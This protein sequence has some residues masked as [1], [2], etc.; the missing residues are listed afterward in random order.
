ML[1]LASAERHFHMFTA[2]HLILLILRRYSPLLVDKKVAM[3]GQGPSPDFCKSRCRLYRGNPSPRRAVIGGYAS[4][5]CSIL[6]LCHEVRC[7][8]SGIDGNDGRPLDS[9]R[10]NCRWCPERGMGTRELRDAHSGF[11][12][13]TTNVGPPC[14]CCHPLMRGRFCLK[15]QGTLSAFRHAVKIGLGWWARRWGRVSYSSAQSTGLER[16]TVDLIDGTKFVQ[17]LLQSLIRGQFR[18]SLLGI[19]FSSDAD[20][21][22]IQPELRYPV[23]II[24]DKLTECKCPSEFIS[25]EQQLIFTSN[26]GNIALPADVSADLNIRRW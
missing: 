23:A 18:L 19:S 2:R 16:L 10:I 25:G 13:R 17:N 6:R 21:A 8:S 24:E 22:L 15:I 4:W 1:W 7:I 9:P 5:C 3:P 11:V 12:Y 26:F 14:Q 20:S